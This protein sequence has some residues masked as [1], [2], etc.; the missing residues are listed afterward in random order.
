MTLSFARRKPNDKR[1]ELGWPLLARNFW[2]IDVFSQKLR[3]S[4]STGCDLW[5]A[6]GADSVEMLTFQY[7]SKAHQIY[8]F[9]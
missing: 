3:A 9:A 4:C 2:E 1:L 6:V 8:G 7:R 5:T